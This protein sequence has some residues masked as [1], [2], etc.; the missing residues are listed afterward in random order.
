M[1]GLHPE[2]G[3]VGPAEFIELP[4]EE[5]GLDRAHGLWVMRRAVTAAAH[6]HRATSRPVPEREFFP[7]PPSAGPE[8]RRPG[9]QPTAPRRRTPAVEPMLELTESVLLREDDTAWA[10]LAALRDTGIRLAIDDFPTGSSLAELPLQTPSTS[11]RS[12][13]PSPATSRPPPGGRSS[14]AS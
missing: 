1:G 8:V 12:T 13:S 4:A 11:L 5:A 10:E 6:W 2:R 3:L 14:T 7:A 9:P